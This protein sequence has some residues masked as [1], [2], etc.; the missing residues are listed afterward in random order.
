M[1]AIP[2]I[3]PEN[4]FK[5]YPNPASQSLTVVLPKDMIQANYRVLDLAGRVVFDGR[6]EVS[7]QILGFDLSEIQAGL[8]IFEAFDTKRVLHQRFIKK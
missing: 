4:E 6:S 7:E 8:Y 2:E 1:T 5:V 3:I